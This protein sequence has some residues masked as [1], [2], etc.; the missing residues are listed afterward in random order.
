M[1]LQYITTI[2][3]ASLLSTSLVALLPANASAS[4]VRGSTTIVPEVNACAGNPCASP[5]NPCAGNPC[6]GS[7]NPCASNPCASS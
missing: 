4:S 1:K 6:A 3:A 2:A 7:K 5:K